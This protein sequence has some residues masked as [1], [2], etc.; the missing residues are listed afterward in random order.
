MLPRT[1][2][3]SL[4]AASALTALRPAPALAP[5]LRRSQR[6]SMLSAQLAPGWITEEDPQSGQVYYFNELTGESQWQPPPDPY[7]Q[8]SYDP[9]SYDPQG[10]DPHSYDYGAGALVLLQ[11]EPTAGVY[12]SY[13]VHNGERQEM[14]RWDMDSPTP[15]I[16]RTQCLIDVSPDGTA[17][18]TS[19][20]K[21]PS[22]LRAPDGEWY[23]VRYGERYVVYDSQEFSLDWLNPETALFTIYIEQ[24]GA[25]QQNYYDTP[26]HVSRY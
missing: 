5:L 25:P 8:Q 17:F 18:I 16:S 4:A 3:V 9:Q 11:V 22:A 23:L 12:N 7:A 2:F 21:S 24:N 14:G 15:Y 10:Y 1:A 19:V 26:E 13:E 6:T 20:G